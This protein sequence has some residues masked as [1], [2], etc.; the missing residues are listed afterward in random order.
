MSC[1]NPLRAYRT[2]TGVVF[3]E[4]AR[5]DI[6]GPIDLPCGMCIGC[7]MRKASDWA[8]RVMHEATLHKEN[9]FVTLTYARDN[10][11]ANASL[12]HGDFQK[13]MKRVR[14]RTPTGVRFYMC[15][16]YGPQTQRPHYHAC[17]FGVDFR[18]RTPKGRGASGK[19]FYDSP[20]LFALWGLGSVT[21]QDLVPQTASY[22]ARYIMKKQLGK[23]AEVFYGERRPDYAAMSLKPGIG[24]GWFAKYKNDVFPHDF[25]IADGSKIR[26]PRYYD[27][28]MKRTAADDMEDIV[29][30][31]EI[32]A[33]QH[34]DDQ[35]PE[36][37]KVREIVHL[38]KVSTLERNGNG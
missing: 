4:L 22:C 28:L 23:S 37:L 20:T 19:D 35:T 36:R 8:L 25:V 32:R 2:P 12:D 21:V 26:P 29:M 11:P 18:D 38:A 5:H 15:G 31:R 34:A 13:F 6:L 30:E 24:A 9:C 7:R 27:K 14:K 3:Q 1:Y 33:R 17:L 16:E 10:M